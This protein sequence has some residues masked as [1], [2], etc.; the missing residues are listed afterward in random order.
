[1]DLFMDK[2]EPEAWNDAERLSATVREN[3]LRHGLTVQETELIKV[4]ASQLNGCVFCL[5][6]HCRQARQA[7]VTQQKL[8]ILPAWREAR[9]YEDRETAVLAVA[10]AATQLPLGEDARADLVAAR[11]VLGDEAF[12]AAEWVAATI[13]LFNRIS[14]LSGHPVR[15]RDA[16]GGCSDERPGSASR[17]DGARLGAAL[18][19]GRGARTAPRPAGRPARDDRAPH[20]AAAEAI[21]G[22]SLVL[23]RPLRPGRR[24]RDRRHGGP[25]HPHTGLATVSWL[26]TGRIDHLDSGGNAAEVRPGELNLMIAGRGITHQEIS[27]PGTRVLHGVQLW[28]ALPE[29]TRFSEHHFAHYA[30][31][32]V[33]A[34]GLT[35]QVFIGELLGSASPVDTRTPELLGAELLL[36]PGASVSLPVRPDFEY[37][38]LAESA[39]ISVNGSTTPHRSLAYVPTGSDTLRIEAGAE[40]TRALLLGGTPLGEQIIMWWNFVGRTHDEIVEYRRRY[41]AEIGLEPTDVQDAGEPALFGPFPDGQRAPLPAPVLPLTRLKPRG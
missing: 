14:I 1:M 34:P 27:T 17:D 8:D 22:R 33:A 25:R 38:V 5:D 24:R 21:P 12:A 9:I 10:E 7:G 6:L 32:P 31:E 11:G 26:F 20:P 29:A 4:R 36:E 40:G 35:A 13:N 19:G 18:H 30:P 39:D 23:P 28:Y 15:P 2:A 41:Q 3:A 37:G 16:G